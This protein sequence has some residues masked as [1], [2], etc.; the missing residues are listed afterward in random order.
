MQPQCVWPRVPERVREEAEP[1][2]LPVE[3]VAV[4]LAQFREAELL[5]V[6][7]PVHTAT[8]PEGTRVPSA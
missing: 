1:G 6:L 2:A 3:A 8:M 5:L 4:Q 7:V